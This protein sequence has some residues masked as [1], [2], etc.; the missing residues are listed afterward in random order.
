MPG[1]GQDHDGPVPAIDDTVSFAVT[2]LEMRKSVNIYLRLIGLSSHID[3]KREKGIRRSE[4]PVT[5]ERTHTVCCLPDTNMDL[6]LMPGQTAGQNAYYTPDGKISECG[7]D[8]AHWQKQSAAN[9]PGSTVAIVPSDN[10]IIGWARAKLF[11]V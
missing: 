6:S 4:E 7:A 10:E 5:V 3:D 1:S 9:D 8:L 11:S 2:K